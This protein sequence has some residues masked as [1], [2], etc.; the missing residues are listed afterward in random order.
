MSTNTVAGLEPIGLRAVPAVVKRIAD[1][2]LIHPN[3]HKMHDAVD[4]WIKEANERGGEAGIAYLAM[5]QAQVQQN[6]DNLAD[7]A[8]DRADLKK[9]LEGLTI[10]DI[11]GVRWRLDRQVRQLEGRS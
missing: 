6:A 4:R 9:G 7:W 3:V 1:A 10:E 8:A 2:A 11:E 5:C